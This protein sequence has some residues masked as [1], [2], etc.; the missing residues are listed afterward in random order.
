MA[1]ILFAMLIDHLESTF[2]QC[3]PY[4]STLNSFKIFENIARFTC[5]C[6]F[7]VVPLQAN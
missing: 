7:F 6:A 1:P 5:V 2:A 4:T 3:S